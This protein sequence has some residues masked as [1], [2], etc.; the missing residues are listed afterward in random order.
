[1]KKTFFIGFLFSVVLLAG[2]F[3]N[4]KED[5]FERKDKLSDYGFFEG[6]LSDLSPAGDVI[7]YDLN[8]ALFSNYA[9]K[10]RFIKVPS[11]A[12]IIYNDTG[13]FNMP[14]GTVL[15]KNFYFTKDF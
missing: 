12:K 9:E 5:H 8:T 10:L 4:R 6:K 13:W 3:T 2:S 11:G 1:M 15:I 14:T 7:P